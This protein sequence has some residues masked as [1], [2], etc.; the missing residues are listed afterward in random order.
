VPRVVGKI[1]R[2]APVERRDMEF[3][4]KNT[5]R[6]AKITLPAVHHEPA[7]QERVL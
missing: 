4:R 7:G 5:D 6:A 1:S 2:G 3:L